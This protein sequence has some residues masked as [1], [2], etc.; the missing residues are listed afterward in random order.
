MRSVM[1][2]GEE[3]GGRARHV[4]VAFDGGEDLED[5]LSLVLVGQPPLDV[6]RPGQGAFNGKDAVELQAGGGDL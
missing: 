6:R 3:M 5:E 2:D 1:G 4:G